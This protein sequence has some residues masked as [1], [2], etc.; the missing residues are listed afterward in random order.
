MDVSLDTAN[1]AANSICKRTADHQAKP[2]QRAWSHRGPAGG[3]GGR[4]QTLQIGCPRGRR[5]SHWEVWARPPAGL[6]RGSAT[7]RS[8]L[9][10]LS[11]RPHAPSPGKVTS[12]RPAEAR[13]ASWKAEGQAGTCPPARHPTAAAEDGQGPSGAEGPGGQAGAKAPG[14]RGRPRPG[15]R[16]GRAGLTSAYLQPGTESSRGALVFRGGP[17]GAR[18]QGGPYVSGPRPTAGAGLSPPR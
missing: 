8:L 6:R 17:V 15:Q 1:S 9:E 2:S 16:V 3:T 13:P 14:G 11:L 18:G 12:C 7:R 5:S 10:E 4:G